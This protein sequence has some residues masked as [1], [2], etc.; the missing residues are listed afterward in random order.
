VIDDEPLILR[1]VERI[2]RD[3]YVVEPYGDPAA[4][5]ERVRSGPP[6]DLA[7]CDLL[8]KPCNGAEIYESVEVTRP[9]RA[10]RM[11]FLTGGAVQPWAVSLLDRVP[12][13][14]LEKPFS[15]ATLLSL[16]ADRLD[17]LGPADGA[18]IAT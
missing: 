16:V 5:L 11:I 8:M 18:V 17:Q 6:F 14:Q 1:L 7:L 10:A 3:R 4:A 13:P 12:N 2:L 15:A 9:D